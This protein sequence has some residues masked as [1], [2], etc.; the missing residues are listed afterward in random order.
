MAV[1]VVLS[2]LQESA[3][4]SSD[5]FCG[6]LVLSNFIISEECKS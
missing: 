2:P 1:Y 6:S 3:N 4:L 5:N